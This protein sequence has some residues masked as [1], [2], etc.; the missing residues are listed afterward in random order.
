MPTGNLGADSSTPGEVVQLLRAMSIR[1]LSR[2]YNPQ[3][4]LFVFRVR[5][6][7][8]GAVQAGLSARYTAIALLGLASVPHATASTVLGPH[9][10]EDVCRRLLNAAAESNNLGDVALSLL[11]AGSLEYADVGAAARRLIALQPVERPHPVVEISWA[12]AALS[13]VPAADSGGLRDRLAARLMALFNPTSNC[14]PHLAG[15]HAGA[16]SH[17]ACFADLIYPIH[18][19]ARYA[20]ATASRPAL[21]ISA[22]CATHLCR[23]QGD[24]GQWWWHYD[25]RTG[26]ILE[27]YPVY[28][29]HQDAM[30]PMG[31]FALRD[32]GGPDYRGAIRLG[33]QWLL[34]APELAGGSLI[35][36]NADLIWR[37]VARREPRKAVRYLQTAASR[38]HASFRVPAVDALF[39]P[40]VIDHEDRPYH[41][42]WLLYAWRNE[43]TQ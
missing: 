27:R 41:L 31:L 2:M 40:R 38:V 10:R 16:R 32:A 4:R 17:V 37:K 15:G 30:G 18:A 29:I 39:P 8:A 7:P 26:A 43:V 22:A 12:L 1:G 35:D 3:E 24:A 23:L 19:L 13:D 5:R 14:F 6:T 25:Y 33:L 34:Y 11:A 42:G 28:A 9:S 36:R 21:D 20:A